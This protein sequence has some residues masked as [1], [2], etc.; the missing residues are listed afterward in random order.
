MRLALLWADQAEDL[1]IVP[2]GKFKPVVRCHALLNFAVDHMNH[3]CHWRE[4]KVLAV[5]VQCRSIRIGDAN[6]GER[7]HFSLIKYFHLTLRTSS[8]YE[9]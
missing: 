2:S 1:V 9:R 5:R 4:I 6:W 8:S 7:F 3:P